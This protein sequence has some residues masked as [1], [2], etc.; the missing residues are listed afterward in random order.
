M[1]LSRKPIGLISCSVRN[2]LESAWPRTLA[3]FAVLAGVA[4][5]LPHLLQAVEHDEFKVKRE[6]VFTFTKKPHIKRDKNRDHYEITFASKGR[7]DVTVVVLNAAGRIIRHLG[8]GVLGPN[9]PRPFQKNALAQTIVWDG[10]NDQGHYVQE[11]N[12][13]KV[14]VSLGLKPQFE[15]TLYWS[16]H[17]RIANNAPLLYA[18]PEGVYY[19]EGQGVDHL[20]L[21]SHEGDYLRTL[22]PFPAHQV[23]K[24]NGLQ[25]HTFPQDGKSLPLKVGYHQGTLLTSGSSAFPGDQE[26]HYGGYPATCM[27]VQ[28]NRIALAHAYLNRLS[29]DGSSGGLPVKGPKTHFKIKLGKG[30][31][32]IAP[33]SMAFSPDGTYLYMTGYIWKT[34]YWATDG[35]CY[36]VVMRMKYAEDKEPEVFLGKIKTDTG[37]G[38]DAKSFCVPTSVDTDNKGRVYV[39]D[40]AN[41]R[42]QIFSPEGK[43]LK[44]LKVD[45]P[46]KIVVDRKSQ[47]MY[48]FAWGAIGPSRKIQKEKNLNIRK[49][50]TTMARLGT[51]E[52]PLQPKPVKM[53]FGYGDGSGGWSETGGQ[54][55]QV[56]VDTFGTTQTVWAVGRKPTIS[57]AEMNW[58]G[59]G[60]RHISGWEQRGVRLL[61]EQKGKWALKRDFASDTK[62]KV[63]QVA[64]PDFSRQRL[65]VN[66]DD[67]MLYVGEDKGFCKSFDNMIRI[68]PAT[69]QTK[70]IF[71]PFDAEDL[72]FD[73]EGRIY[74]RTDTLVMRFDFKDR[75]E[76]PWDYGEERAK[77]WF[78]GFS[79]PPRSVPATA[80]LAIPGSRPVWWHMSGMAI[81]ASGLLAVVCNIRAKPR[82]RRPKDKAM[83]SGG[84]VAPKGFT[85]TQYPGRGGNRIICVIDPHGK[86]IHQDAVP[87]MTNADGIGIDRDGDLYAMIAAPRVLK[88]KPYFN[89]KS[90]TLMKFKP[91]KTR[92]VAAGRAPVPLPKEN[93]PKRSPDIR[94]GG[95]GEAWAEGAE[96]LYGGVGYGGMGGSCTCWH[97]RFHLDYLGR[98][99]VPETRRFKVAVLDSNGNL[100]LRIGRYGNVEDGKPLIEDGG[101]QKPR[102]I[103]GDEVALVHAPY[104][105]THTDH[106]L[107]I[108]DPGNGRILSVKL[109]YHANEVLSIGKEERPSR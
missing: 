36:H 97:A 95:L 96:W 40:Y 53:P 18:A 35:D 107:Y 8:S 87:G 65:Y 42:I 51:F 52:K 106:R 14:R 20:K 54:V 93:Q 75:R 47:E 105:T 16:P 92:F 81:N 4:C 103:G 41:N 39:S 44:S 45:T 83:F 94:K 12:A 33:T 21:Y 66:P 5:S 104:L 78:Q 71:L 49:I 38:S 57:V 24:V 19:C 37:Y 70:K 17:K 29:T 60:T 22:Y 61:V 62:K 10:K 50:G 85:L 55:Y 82:D 67:G 13:H 102:S 56:A 63:T 34:S 48:V 3:L 68:D 84:F 69:G 76:I 7:C 64:P 79:A 6:S 30:T 99:F 77:V 88:G 2:G 91:G 73:Q 74:M 46:A 108:S 90:E 101:P 23:E 27:A 98:S 11:P 32:I 15:R 80:A 58:S 26:G 72:V 31:K 25:H 9:A 28:G 86:T 1:S 89:G 100:I 59:S 43:L 109:D